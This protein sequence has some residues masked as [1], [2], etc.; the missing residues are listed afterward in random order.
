MQNSF[1]RNIF[2]RSSIWGRT[3]KVY[4]VKSKMLVKKYIHQI[5]DRLIRISG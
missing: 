2:V 5:N 1:Y 4:L 3:N